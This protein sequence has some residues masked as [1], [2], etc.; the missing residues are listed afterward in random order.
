MGWIFREIGNDTGVDGIIEIVEGEQATGRLLAVQSKSGKSYVQ[1]QLGN[2]II[3]RVDKD[4]FMYWSNYAVPVIYCAYSPDDGKIYW[5]HISINNSTELDKSYKFELPRSN[6][7]EE[8]S[9]VKLAEIADY[10]SGGIEVSVDSFED[11]SHA[12]ANRCAIK[13]IISGNPTRRDVKSIIVEYVLKYRKFRNKLF[14]FV[15]SDVI[16]IFCYLSPNDLAANAWGC[17]ALWISK[18][19]DES[20]APAKFEGESLS[21]DLVVDW[22]VSV[23]LLR[24]LYLSKVDKYGYLEKIIP[25][26]Q[27]SSMFVEFAQTM[28]ELNDAG[29]LSD[30]D[31]D[32]KLGKVFDK[33]R[34]SYTSSTRIGLPPNECLSLSIRFR[35][36]MAHY[37]NLFMMFSRKEIESRD[38]VNR[39]WLAKSY[40]EHYKESFSRME[41]EKERVYL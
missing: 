15:N 23:D 31:L 16:W 41:Y 38:R 14:N 26:I 20:F 1:E 18:T 6:R 30:E 36:V 3:A 19:L 32:F 34:E 4:H 33:A 24:L 40:I 13:L 17:R 22:N 27:E 12:R 25:Y 5:Q 7:L 35:E 21:D 11:N 10:L 29:Q 9:K 2:N 28:I 37:D 39:L 8:L